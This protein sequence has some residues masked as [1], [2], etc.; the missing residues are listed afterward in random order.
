MRH[1]KQVDFNLKFDMFFD[2]T[3]HYVEDF[4]K[5]FKN[6]E[7]LLEYDPKHINFNDVIYF[8]SLYSVLFQLVL[9]VN[10][11]TCLLNQCNRD[12]ERNTETFRIFKLA[13]CVYERINNIVYG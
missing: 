3:Q 6:S 8:V 7:Y 2:Y 10:R 13:N 12:S 1:D 4:E 9:G 5:L 11:D